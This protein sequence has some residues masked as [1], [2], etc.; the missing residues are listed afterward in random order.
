MNS[1]EQIADLRTLVVQAGAAPELMVVLLHGYA[2]G[3][4]D[5]A[6]FGSSLGVPGW[7]LFPQGP[8]RGQP[9][10][11]AWWQIDMAAREAAR[12]NA[13][14][15]LAAVA[16]SG[17]PA[18]REQLGRFI[19]HCRGRYRPRRLVVGGFSQ[20]GMLACDWQLR[21]EPGA[22]A[23]LLMSASRLNT[24][25]WGPRASRLQGLPMLISHGR[26][27]PDLAFAAGE[28]LCAL[29]QGAD[30]R[31]TWTPFDGGHEI[32]LPVWRA[33]RGFLRGLVM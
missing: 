17:L 18:A 3:P 23:L 10:G 28:K 32:P 4:E 12:A 19:A 24:P 21:A 15:D 16:P 2:M 33:V 9:G 29:A 5:L 27:D 8:V 25:D 30:A 22:D 20:G 7:Y 14:R 26:A 13:P 31:V 11:H 6:P 1:V